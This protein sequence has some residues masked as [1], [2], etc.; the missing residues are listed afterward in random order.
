MTET[1]AGEAIWHSFNRRQKKTVLLPTKTI[2]Q[3]GRSIFLSPAFEKKKHCRNNK[4]P[5]KESLLSLSKESLVFLWQNVSNL[6][7]FILAFYNS[8]ITG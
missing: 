1:S 3:I 6:C 7:Q 2:A 8:S 4:E 5:D